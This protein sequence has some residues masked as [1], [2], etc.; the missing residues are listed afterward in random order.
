ME[1]QLFRNLHEIYDAI[2]VIEESLQGIG[3]QDYV[4]DRK[5]MILVVENFDNVLNLL[6]KVPI[7]FME[8][9]DEIKW[10]IF[11][12]LRVKFHENEQG[13]NEEHVWNA[14]KQQLNKLAKFLRKILF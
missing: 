1:Q 8:Q 14:S 13:I 11:D 3:F 5:K 4:R 12:Q 2:S 6:L 7:T 9:H 10:Q